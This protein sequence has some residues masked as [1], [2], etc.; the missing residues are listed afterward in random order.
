[1]ALGGK[2]L[3]R[4]EGGSLFGSSGVDKDAMERRKA[5]AQA[6]IGENV[7][8]SGGTLG[9]GIIVDGVS[10]DTTGVVSGYP[11]YKDKAEKGRAG[12]Q[13]ILDK[14]KLEGIMCQRPY[15]DNIRNRRDISLNGKAYLGQRSLYVFEEGS[16]AIFEYRSLWRTFADL[17]LNEEELAFVVETC[18]S[19]RIKPEAIHVL[20]ST[21]S[22][23]LSVL[24][25]V[26]NALYGSA[27]A[28]L[29]RYF[30][31]GAVTERELEKA[32][33]EP[34]AA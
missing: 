10:Q 5:G 12:A 11:S 17:Q 16:A 20:M 29:N 19:G 32:F 7:A 28:D 8:E 30:V 24:I 4:I 13:G 33:R 3:F 31:K 25:G 27:V 23:A 2:P 14:L 9:P 34:E 15:P 6:D 26:V 21:E 18:F 22:G 1:M